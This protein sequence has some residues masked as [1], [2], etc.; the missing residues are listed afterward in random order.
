MQEGLVL[1]FTERYTCVITFVIESV[2]LYMF[3]GGVHIGYGF[4]WLGYE[5]LVW[6]I[7]IITVS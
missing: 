2:V 3:Y 7:H 1:L 5:M 4:C 6:Y